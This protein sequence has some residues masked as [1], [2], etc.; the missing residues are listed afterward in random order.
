MIVYSHYL[1]LTVTPLPPVRGI[2]SA[3]LV[4]G[5][6]EGKNIMASICDT[7]FNFV[8]ARFHLEACELT[9][10]SN[11]RV[12]LLSFTPMFTQGSREYLHSSWP[13]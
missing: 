6:D 4:R 13:S 9:P 11:H 8:P 7:H 1:S 10:R 5:I 2:Q 3:Y 12:E